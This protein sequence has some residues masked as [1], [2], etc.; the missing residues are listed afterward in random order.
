MGTCDK[1]G[2]IASVGDV[3]YK[4]SDSGIAFAKN[5]TA[6]LTKSSWSFSVWIFSIQKQVMTMS[7]AKMM[8]LIKEN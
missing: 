1:C 8:I 7:I 2:Y 5:V 3:Y 4:D 6:V